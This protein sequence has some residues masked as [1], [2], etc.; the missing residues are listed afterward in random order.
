MTL[1]I[2]IA[3]RWL[4]AL[5]V[6]GFMLWFVVWVVVE[7]ARGRRSEKPMAPIRFDYKHSRWVAT[8]GRDGLR[9]HWKGVR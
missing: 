1:A 3:I 9:K 7:Y 2:A 5:L 6:A 4:L 8:D